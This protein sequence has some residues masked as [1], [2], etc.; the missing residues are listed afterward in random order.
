MSIGSAV[1]REFST[2]YCFILIY[3]YNTQWVWLQHRPSKEAVACRQACYGALQQE[4]KVR[5]WSSQVSLMQLHNS[6]QL[7]PTSKGCSIQSMVTSR[8]QTLN[9]IQ[10][11]LISFLSG[12]LNGMRRTAGTLNS[13]HKTLISEK[14]IKIG[15]IC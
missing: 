7:G 9:A 8:E 3:S 13:K 14:I 2:V 10:S 5:F 12:D 15:L 6:L 11:R 4:G 1:D